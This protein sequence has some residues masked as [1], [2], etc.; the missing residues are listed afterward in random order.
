VTEEKNELT[1]GEIQEKGF[2]GFMTDAL[3]YVQRALHY[4]SRISATIRQQLLFYP[5]IH[6]DEETQ[7]IYKQTNTIPP[8]SELVDRLKE[9][10]LNYIVF[11][12]A[13]FK[14]RY[15][16]IPIRVIESPEYR[17]QIAAF[18]TLLYDFKHNESLRRR[19]SILD[20]EDILQFTDEGLGGHVQFSIR[21]IIHT[22]E[23]NKP[24]ANSGLEISVQNM[25][26][27]DRPLERLRTRSEE[28]VFED[29]MDD[30]SELIN[31]SIRQ[32]AEETN[33]TFE[34]PLIEERPFER[35]QA[36]QQQRPRGYQVNTG[37]VK[38]NVQDNGDS[39][40]SWKNHRVPKYVDSGLGVRDWAKKIIFMVDFSRKRPMT[41]K[42]KCQLLLEN[43]P[44]KNF[45]SIMQ[46]FSESENKSDDE[47]IDIIEDELQIDES[48]ASLNLA[49]LKFNDDRD[50]D[51]KRFFEKIKKLVRIKYPN[52]EN[53]G[54]LTTS[55]EHFEKLLPLCV[56]N[57]ENW[58]LDVYD[59]TDP[60]SRV[61][62]ANRL[63]NLNKSRRSV[64]AISDAKKT[65][66]QKNNSQSETRT[67]AHCG[68]R[69]YIRPE[70]RLAPECFNCHR[71]GHRAD[72]CRSP[73]EQQ[74]RTLKEE[75]QPIF[76]EM[77]EDFQIT[78]KILTSKMKEVNKAIVEAFDQATTRA[79]RIVTASSVETRN[80][81]QTTV[82][83]TKG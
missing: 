62:L 16:V 30:E 55:M 51:L 48:E 28:T 50:K 4:T 53:T 78:V 57:S 31:E 37:E 10:N 71:R 24:I 17:N 41:S 25:E 23:T 33:R 52:L 7:E 13:T 42:E 19:T 82:L 15:F 61:T 65:G 22:V 3:S 58:G 26:Q 79:N 18:A 70:C 59:D 9:L 45:G 11:I 29:A 49:N 2:Y 46:A 21:V 74:S 56:K 8:N 72:E 64:N 47:L 44:A 77:V 43:I 40:E 39:S 1:P 66:N 34:S 76:E 54:V 68:R 60:N 81:G 69:G 6:L 80:I 27:E 83:K 67:C 63:Y 35:P 20:V 14:G 75:D 73:R 12:F 32:D 38:P 5:L 36:N